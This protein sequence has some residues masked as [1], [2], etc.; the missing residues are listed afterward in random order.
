VPII[1]ILLRVV[2]PLSVEQVGQRM[3]SLP[4]DSS[5]WRKPV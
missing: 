2:G 5:V 3:S 4:M 1:P